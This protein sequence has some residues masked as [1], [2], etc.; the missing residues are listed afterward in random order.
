MLEQ[1]REFLRPED[2]HFTLAHDYPVPPPVLWQWLN[3]PR[4]IIHWAQREMHPAARPGGRTG[5]GAR[6]HCVHG[7]QLSM[8]ETVLDWRPFEYF[9]VDQESKALPGNFKMTYQL[10]PTPVG[11]HLTWS[12]SFHPKLPVPEFIARAMCLGIARI[13]SMDKEL[14]HLAHL[15]ADDLK[16]ELAP[17]PALAASA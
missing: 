6:N 4:K 12:T 14:D 7:Q 3:D 13:F 8:V 11:T 16:G 10:E 9:T 17:S 15:I 5:P 1:R 2:A